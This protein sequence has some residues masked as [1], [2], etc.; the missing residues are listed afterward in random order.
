MEPR[1]YEKR[2]Q[3]WS[4]V[5]RPAALSRSAR[6]STLDVILESDVRRRQIVTSKVDHRT[7]KNNNV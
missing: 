1:K 7:E 4:N 2:N 3:C 6:G 5:G